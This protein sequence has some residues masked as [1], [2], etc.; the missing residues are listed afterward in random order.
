MKIKAQSLIEFAVILMSVTVVAILSLQIVS[1]KINS[2]DYK[3]EAVFQEK[4]QDTSLEETNCTKMGLFWDK[5]NGV[6]EAR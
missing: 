2:T 4:V 6:C 5:Q 1:N 3:E